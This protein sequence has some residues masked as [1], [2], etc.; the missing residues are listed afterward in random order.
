M[1]LIPKVLC[2]PHAVLW[3]EINKRINN[4]TFYFNFTCQALIK[5]K[6]CES[7][8]VISEKLQ[9]Q[10]A[11]MGGSHNILRWATSDDVILGDFCG[12]KQAGNLKRKGVCMQTKQ[13][14]INTSPEHLKKIMRFC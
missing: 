3:R 5:L 7:L 4:S 2:E 12:Y 9:T 6:T 1:T 13:S 10:L 14:T 11:I 8:E